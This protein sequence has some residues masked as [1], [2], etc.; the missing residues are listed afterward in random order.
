[1]P[2]PSVDSGGHQAVV[3][4]LGGGH[5]V[6]EVGL[7]LVEGQQPHQ[8][9]NQSEDEGRKHRHMV[10]LSKGSITL[11]CKWRRSRVSRCSIARKTL[12]IIYILEW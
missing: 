2:Q 9:R 11:Y 10:L 1:M 4:F 3:G 5:L 6:R 7:G 8:H 12:V